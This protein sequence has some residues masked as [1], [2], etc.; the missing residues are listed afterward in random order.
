MKFSFIFG[1]KKLPIYFWFVS[2]KYVFKYKCK[3]TTSFKY[4][5]GR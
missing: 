1:A 4:D 2:E 5:I 3:N